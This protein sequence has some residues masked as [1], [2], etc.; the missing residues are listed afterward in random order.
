LT[1]DTADLAWVTADAAGAAD[2]LIAAPDSR[3]SPA[4][5]PFQ[6]RFSGVSAPADTVLVM[7]PDSTSWRYPVHRLPAHR[8]STARD[9][10]E[11]W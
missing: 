5:M 11:R 3:A 7:F 9:R 10:A 2:A 8:V 4:A 1:W 6:C